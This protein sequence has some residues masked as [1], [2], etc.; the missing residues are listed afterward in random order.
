VVF[1]ALFFFVFTRRVFLSSLNTI[2]YLPSRIYS[3]AF[4]SSSSNFSSPD[5]T[6]SGS[7]V[8]GKL[9]PAIAHTASEDDEDDEEEDDH[10]QD[11][12]RAHGTTRLRYLTI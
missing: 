11:T 9:V 1:N 12:M 10:E 4:F 2:F 6:E 7:R 8:V 5:L 3:H